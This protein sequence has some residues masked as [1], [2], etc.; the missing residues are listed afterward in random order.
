MVAL[1]PAKVTGVDRALVFLNE[2]C[3][4]FFSAMSVSNNLIVCSPWGF[5]KTRAGHV[6]DHGDHDHE[7]YHDHDLDRD[8]DHHHHDHA[9]DDAD[10]DDNDDDVDRR[11][12][13]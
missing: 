12:R 5:R 6:D 8:H 11:Q 7:H 13:P 9:D 2:N 4:V 3:D 10:D 1:V